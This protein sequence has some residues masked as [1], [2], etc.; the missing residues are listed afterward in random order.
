ME[1]QHAARFLPPGTVSRMENLLFLAFS[2][3]LPAFDPAVQRSEEESRM[4]G[5]SWSLLGI[6]TDFRLD[7]EGAL[8]PY[9]LEANV[10]YICC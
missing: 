10:C 5:R 1:L 4:L 8:E 2:R 3:L 7:N 9:V 6:D